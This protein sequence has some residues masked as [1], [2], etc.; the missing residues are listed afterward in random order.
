MNPDG[1]VNYA[2]NAGFLGHDKFIYIVQDDSGVISNSAKVS[3]IVANPA[4]V[5][6]SIT[7]APTLSEGTPA[8]YSATASVA[9]GVALTYEWN[10]G[11]GTATTTGQTINHT[12]GQNGTYELTL[13]VISATGNRTSQTQTIKV[14]NIA[15]TV[16]AGNGLT[17]NGSYSDRT[18][19]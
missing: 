9:T 15:P 19:T 12:Y 5:I 4:P 13:T 10:F 6:D 18:V 16:I 2:P 3:I 14:N 17:L 7:I 11:D 8:Q 1:T